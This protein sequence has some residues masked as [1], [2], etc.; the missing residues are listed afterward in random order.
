[1]RVLRGGTV[2]PKMP[3]TVFLSSSSFLP[4]SKFLLPIFPSKS[5]TGAFR[6]SKSAAVAIET[7]TEV[8]TKAMRNTEERLRKRKEKRAIFVSRF[9]VKKNEAKKKETEKKKEEKSV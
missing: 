2:F 4:R 3:P 8:N 6:P 7:P 5:K 1:M 9:R